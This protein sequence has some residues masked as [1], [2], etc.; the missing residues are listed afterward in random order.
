MAEETMRRFAL[1]VDQLPVWAFLT[2]AVLVFGAVRAGRLFALLHESRGGMELGAILT[3]GV[4]LT[5]VVFAI[6]RRH[7]SAWRSTIHVLGATIAG[8]AFGLVLIWPFVP[9][10]Y[11]V[12]LAAMLRDTVAAGLMMAVVSLPAAIALLWLSRRFGSHSQLTERRLRVIQEQWRRR[13][14]RDHDATRV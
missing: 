6:R 8:N 11:H 5:I 12:S 4:F 9:D 7:I 13:F 2:G 10:T 3:V 14:A 1:R